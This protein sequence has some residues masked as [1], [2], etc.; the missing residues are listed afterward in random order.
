MYICMFI[1]VKTEAKIVGAGTSQ[2][3]ASTG[4]TTPS[5]KV[6]EDFDC[7]CHQVH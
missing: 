7:F 4:D 6:H 1:A 2:A 5:R 3:M